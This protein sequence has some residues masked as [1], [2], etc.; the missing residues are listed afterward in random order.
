MKKVGVGVVLGVLVFAL[1]GFSYSAT[2]ASTSAV[3]PAQFKALQKRVTKLEKV[4]SAL[5][6]YTVNCLF[7][8][9]AVS[10]NGTPPSSGYVYRDPSGESLRSALDFAQSGQTLSGYVSFT[11]TAECAAPASNVRAALR[12]AA[13]R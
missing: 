1:A 12:S 2:R 11:Q 9:Q 6:A 5:A 4:T 13:A 7:S 10:R 8:W 3:T